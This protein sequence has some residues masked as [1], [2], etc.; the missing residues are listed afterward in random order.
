MSVT[1]EEAHSIMRAAITDRACPVSAGQPQK[2]WL[3]HVARAV[4]MNFNRLYD[5]YA[6][7]TVPRWH[8]GETILNKAEERRRLIAR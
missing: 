5:I 8:E 4:G 1:A 2:V 7:E 3:R 6:G